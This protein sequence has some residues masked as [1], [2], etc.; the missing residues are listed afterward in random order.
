MVSREVEMLE[1]HL[2]WLRRR[3]EVGG[4]ARYL[5]TDLLRG[6]VNERVWKQVEM[7]RDGWI[8]L[9]NAGERGKRAV[10]G[11]QAQAVTGGLRVI[12]GIWINKGDL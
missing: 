11:K 5:R 6:S 2:L 4:R 1:W 7:T 9:D 10:N 12:E 8:L 3:G